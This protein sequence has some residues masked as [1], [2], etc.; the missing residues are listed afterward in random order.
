MRIKWQ[1]A[2]LVK[3]ENKSY[4][5]CV[6]IFMEK[7]L[8]VRRWESKLILVVKDKVSFL[9]KKILLVH[10]REPKSVPGW[11]VSIP[12][13]ILSK[14]SIL[15]SI[16][17]INQFVK[18]MQYMPCE[19]TSLNTHFFISCSLVMHNISFWKFHKFL[20]IIRYI[21]HKTYLLN[22]SFSKNG[23][24]WIDLNDITQ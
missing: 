3:W 4:L 5:F 19:E 16:Y 23:W 20:S 10:R 21:K 1:D 2:Y 11:K 24:N 13:K 9:W 14:I 12:W 18:Q 22:S 7:I 17:G 15:H 6:F 8:L